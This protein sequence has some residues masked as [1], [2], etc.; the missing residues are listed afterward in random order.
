[1]LWLQATIAWSKTSDD[2]C[3]DD[4]VSSNQWSWAVNGG[5]R[6]TKNV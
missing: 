1:M 3:K 4:E 2:L 5:D 6:S